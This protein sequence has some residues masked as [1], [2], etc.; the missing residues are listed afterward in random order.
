[1]KTKPH[2]LFIA[3]ALLLTLSSQPSIVLAQGTAFTY[4][5][6]LNDNGNPANGSYD[7]RFTLYDAV[8]NGT[9][10]GSLTNPA[11]GAS[12]GL[13]TVTLDFGGIF[14]GSNYWLEIAAR[15]NGPGSPDSPP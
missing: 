7:L 1:M 12:N 2:G 3:L 15:T 13:F 4:N 9:A 10:F 11:T 8:T 14:T 5:G 6:R